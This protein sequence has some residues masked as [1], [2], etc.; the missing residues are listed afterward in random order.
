[1]IR[2]CFCEKIMQTIDAIIAVMLFI[3]LISGLRDGLVKQVTGL[4]GFIGGLLLGRS[5]YM[6]V[7]EWITLTFDV[8]SEVAHITA[9]ILILI[10]V[11]LLLNLIG[12]GVSK[13]LSIISLGWMNRLL[14]GL[15]GLLKFALFSGVVI[16]GIELFDQHDVFVAEEKKESSVL[17]YPLYEATDIFFNGIKEEFQGM[18]LQV[19][20][21]SI[22]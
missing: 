13:L 2:D 6:S 8:S 22:A 15:V 9:F 1:M 11:P 21:N 20:W 17:Y 10:V 14:G 19:V 16:T 5:F 7:G 3:G 4:V 12:W 18:N